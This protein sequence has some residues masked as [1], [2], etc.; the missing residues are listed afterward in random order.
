MDFFNYKDGKL[1]C[2]DVDLSL[3]SDA[4]NTPAYVY[5]KKTLE[6]HAD[7]YLKSFS[8]S[9]NLVC[10][11]VK[12]L[13]NISILKILK[14]RGCG[15]DIVSGGELHRVLLAGADP[16]K[17]IFS[18]VGKTKEEIASGIKNNVLSFNIES[19][20]ELYRI[21]RVAKDLDRVA[22]ISIRFNPDVDSGGHDYIT[23]GR[24]GDKFGISSIEDIL[25]LSSYISSS[26][27]LKIVGVACHIGSQI[28]GLDSYKAAARKTIELA[29]M[30]LEMGIELDFLDLGGGLGV[31][32]NGETPPSPSELVA[33]L[34]N[35][36]SERKERIIIE[37]GRSI[38]A[39]AGVLLT[40]VEYIKDKFLIVDAAMNDLLR[41]ALY[42]A[43]HDV[44]NLEKDSTQEAKVWNIVGPICESSDF[45]ARNI[46]IPAKEDD[47]LAIKSAGAYGFVMSSNYNSRPKSAEILVDGSEFKLIRKRENFDDL[48]QSEIG[49]DD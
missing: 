16:K 9:N 29:D 21:E 24:K 40:K 47:V 26:K 49:L 25:E 39:N 37:P 19:P 15:F 8:S 17:I 23:T 35:E 11:A 1:F 2:E 12:S 5:S 43:E 30:L 46:S 38:S 42:K 32:Y 20:S 28:L 6:R 48:V 45:L 10:F 14:D 31:P 3:I 34:E 33:C 13:S 18:G 41:P 4:F 7:A 22:P 27:N 44:W 36:L